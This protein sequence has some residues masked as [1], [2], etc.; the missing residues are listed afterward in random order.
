[1]ILESSVEPHLF[2]SPVPPGQSAVQR[3]AYYQQAVHLP[4]VLQPLRLLLQQEFQLLEFLQLGLEFEKIYLYLR[5]EE[6]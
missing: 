4:E 6:L 2:F 1:M 3:P 5:K